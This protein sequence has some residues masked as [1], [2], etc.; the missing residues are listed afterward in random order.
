MTGILNILVAAARSDP[1]TECFVVSDV[2]W[3]QLERDGEDYLTQRMG[4]VSTV[5]GLGQMAV[6]GVP[7]TRCRSRYYAGVPFVE[8]HSRDEFTGHAM[9]KRLL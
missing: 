8:A 1:M 4:H 7:V 6:L 9:I 2:C 5:Q 3:V